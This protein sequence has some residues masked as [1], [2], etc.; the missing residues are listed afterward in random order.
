MGSTI[1]NNQVKIN[2]IATA[3]A[4]GLSHIKFNMPCQDIVCHKSEDNIF[5]LAL[6]DGAGSKRLS[7]IGAKFVT[8]LV[9]DIL[10]REFDMLWTLDISALTKYIYDSLIEQLKLCAYTNN[11][12][13]DD[14]SSTLLFAAI[15]RD[16]L[17]WGHIGDGVIG[18][19]IDG[20]LSCLSQP[21]NFDFA[22]VTVFITSSDAMGYFKVGKCEVGS[23]Y[24]IVLMSDGSAES[25]Y[26]KKNS[27]LAP[28]VKQLFGWLKERSEDVVSLALKNNLENIIR[29]RTTD[30]CSIALLLSSSLGEKKFS[31]LPKE[32]LM[33]LFESHDLSYIYR[34]VRV[35][36]DMRA[37]PSNSLHMKSSVGHIPR[38]TLKRY[39]QIFKKLGLI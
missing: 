34:A 4:K 38:K 12:T 14:L 30:D 31:D 35:L 19:F 10:I 13:L 1:I 16:R 28:A 17:I 25:L 5:S 36:D 8:D 29:K 22:N 7:Q 3:S 37:K 9:C 20:E 11:C 27:I 39:L 18:Q 2:R 6:A 32:D 23:D 33:S 24:G 15:N 26:N 21:T